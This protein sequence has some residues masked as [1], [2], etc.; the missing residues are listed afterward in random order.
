MEAF[1]LNFQGFM[2]IFARIVGLLN[3]SPIYASGAITLQ[4][5]MIFAF[6]LTVVLYPVTAKFLPPIPSG[7]AEF[8]LIIAAELLMGIFMGFLISII[9]A[10]FQMAGQYFS[11]QIGFGY[12]EV[13]D[14]VSQTNLPVIS[15][16]KNM[17]GM[18]IFLITGAHRYLLESLYYS[19]EQVQVLAFTAKIN[20]GLLK[21]L[22]LAVGSM[23]IVAFKI[24]LPVMGILVLVSIAE[25]LMGKAAPQLNILQ[26]SFPAKIAVGLLVMIVITPFIVQQMSIGI[27]LSLD[28]LNLLLR[29]WPQ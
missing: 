24:A 14:P 16:L 17:L 5:R 7:T 1:V 23:F 21:T 13:L 4:L 27:E 2:F 11:V 18:L 12:T 22:E 10:S 6:L 20:T 25:A 8:F 19:F 26:L 9:F 28:R 29:D 3:S 15:T